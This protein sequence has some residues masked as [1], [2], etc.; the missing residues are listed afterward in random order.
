LIAACSLA[1]AC[2]ARPASDAAWTGAPVY[3]RDTGKLERLTAD[4]NGDGRTDT[5]AFMD[6]IYTTRIEIDR[7]GDGKPDR[8]EHYAPNVSPGA[9][10]PSQIRRAE[11][12]DGRGGPVTRRETYAAGL[13]ERVE[14]DTDADGRMDKWEHYVANALVRV[15][16]DLTGSGRP[17]RR[18]IYSA[19]VVMAVEVDP[20]GDGTF[21]P[22][23]GGIS[24]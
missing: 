4:R 3:N 16:L 11:E 22:A 20:E 8:W 1:L 21:V 18:L 15:D 12:S 10:A 7:D 19:G 2:D 23:P 9:G 13:V 24:K 5:W 6:G 17:N 14:E